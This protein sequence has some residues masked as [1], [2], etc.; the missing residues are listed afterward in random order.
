MLNIGDQ[1]GLSGLQDK[2]VQWFKLALAQHGPA[3][4]IQRQLLS[5][6]PFKFGAD[7]FQ[8]QKRWFK[9][10]NSGQC[11]YDH[12]DRIYFTPIGMLVFSISA[13]FKGKAIP[14]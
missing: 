13:S 7:C 5:Y 10:E 1:R 2:K 6:E 14:N 8:L 9:K 12:V 11:H 4:Q 3:R